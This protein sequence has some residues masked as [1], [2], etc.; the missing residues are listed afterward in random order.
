MSLHYAILG[1][2]NC[3][4][5]TGY[6]LKKLIDQSINHFWAAHISQIYRELGALEGEG[7]V[8]SAIEAQ[9]DRPD[10]RIYTV[11]EAGSAAFRQWVENP[12]DKLSKETR[13]EFSLRI[14]F[15]AEAGPQ[16]VTGMLRRF[17][18]QKVEERDHTIPAL[19]SGVDRMSQE[20]SGP[21]H[22]PY[23][24]LIEKRVRM[25]NEMLIRWAEE[26]IEELQKIH[27]EGENNEG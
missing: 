5:M 19:F 17:L 23:W 21:E 22:A 24:R 4:P 1:L 27:K 16:E 8:T 20:F 10:K 14:F 15:G 11:T 6:D 18:Q 13:D 7:Y 2:L 25:T 26:G 3:K 9:Q 12:P